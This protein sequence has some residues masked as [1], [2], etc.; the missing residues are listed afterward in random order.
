MTAALPVA[1]WE[2]EVKIGKFKIRAYVLEGGRRVL[3]PEDVARFFTDGFPKAMSVEI[4]HD[5][6]QLAEFAAG[7]GIPTTALPN[8]TPPERAN[9]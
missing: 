2:G 6:R 3:N 7:E 1:V 8:E 4:V 9:G 5:M